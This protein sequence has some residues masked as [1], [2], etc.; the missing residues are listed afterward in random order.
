[1]NNCNLLVTQE[2]KFTRAKNSNK[3]FFL[4]K[5]GSITNITND[6]KY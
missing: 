6:I 3:I 4:D 1:M 5:R 2:N